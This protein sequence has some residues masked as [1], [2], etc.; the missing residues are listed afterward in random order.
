MCM[1]LIRG[2]RVRILTVLLLG[3]VIAAADDP[4]PRAYTEVP[5]I[6]HGQAVIWHDPG[7]VDQ[8]DLR[9]GIGGEATAP[10]AP[11]TFVKEDTGGSQPKVEVQD[12]NGRKWMIKFGPEATPDTFATRLAWAVGYWVEPNYFVEDGVISGARNLTRARGQVDEKGNFHD[13]RFQ[14]RSSSPEYLDNINWNWDANPFVGT[15]ELNGLKI[16]MM[17][18]SNWDDKDFRDAASRGS[19]NA[20]Y[21]DG[22][23]YIF[24]IDDWGASFG[25]WGGVLKR[26]KWNCED[27]YRQ[28][29]NFVKSMQ[30]GSVDWGYTGQHTRLMTAG[31]RPADAKWLMQYLGKIT[32]EQLHAGLISSGASEEQA[33]YCARGIRDRIQQLAT[34]ANSPGLSTDRIN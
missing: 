5:A 15:P 8:L 12:A 9:Y 28:S 3:V 4:A 34:V 17:L 11:F 20:I 30:P 6:A 13:G 1:G 19:N 2:V 16:M 18:V 7:A 27:Y 33:S 23:R 10:K 25:T 22:D 14:L 21:K 24:F 26:S 31:V 29:K 32:D